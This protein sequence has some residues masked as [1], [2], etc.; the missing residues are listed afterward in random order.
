MIDL[1][2]ILLKEQSMANILL[3]EPDYKNKYPPLGLMKISTYHKNRKDTVVFVKGT[4]LTIKKSKWD[5]IYIATL[6]TFHWKKTVATINYYLKSVDNPRDIFC[7]GVMAT[8]LK[9]QINDLFDITIVSGLLDKKGVLGPDNVI[10][11]SLTPD[12]SIINTKENDSLEYEYPANNSYIAYATR[13]CVRNC[14]FCAVPQIEPDFVSYI[15]IK[16]QINYIKNNYGERKNLLLLDN[17]VLA[18]KHFDRIIEDIKELGFGKG[19]Y[20]ERKIKDRKYKSK[21]YVDFNQGIDARLLSREKCEKLSEIAINPLRIAFD[22]ADPK[23]VE[24]Y[25]E[26]V[27]MAA[28]LGITN[29]SNYVLFNFEDTPEDLYNRLE[30]NLRLNNEFN[31]KGYKT[32]IWSF[33]M[34]YCP[35]KGTNSKDR[36]YIGVNWNRKYLRAIQCIL[37]ATH[38]VVSTNSDFF[39][40]AFGKD[41]QDFIKILS[42]PED[43]I[44]NRVAFEKNGFV[45]E[46]H[47]AFL[48]LKKENPAYSCIMNEDLKNVDDASIK[49]SDILKY[50]KRQ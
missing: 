16:P 29:L 8:L 28:D 34:K 31:D 17:N 46:W 35:I 20:F 27:R 22:S 41:L 42:M 49:R 44:L 5:R 19:A 30:I 26:K 45:H 40:R 33:P 11:D 2:K 36:K 10:V 6:F 3:V 12:Y 48:G 14:L 25:V 50:Y 24:L 9:D 43:Y 7:G 15:D 1:I 18:S 13:G 37:N 47:R 32:K 39:Y 23:L 21:R 4:N 38:G